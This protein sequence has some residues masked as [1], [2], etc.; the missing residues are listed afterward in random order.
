MIEKSES[1]AAH[2]TCIKLALHRETGYAV[3]VPAPMFVKQPTPDPAPDFILEPLDVNPLEVQ[4][5]ADSALLRTQPIGIQMA[6]GIGRALFGRS[7]PAVNGFDYK[8]QAWVKDG[9][10][11]SCGHPKPCTC[12]G[13]THEGQSPALDAE[14]H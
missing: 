7:R 12:Y 13:T 10:Y 5:L 8:H 1:P 11:V 3:G 4:L 6:D 9:K 2:V 14:I